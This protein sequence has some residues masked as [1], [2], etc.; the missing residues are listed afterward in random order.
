MTKQKLNPT[1]QIR[2]SRTT[3]LASCVECD[4]DEEY[5]LSEWDSEI[6]VAW[7]GSCQEETKHV[8]VENDNVHNRSCVFPSFSN[9]QTEVPLES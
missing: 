3:I 7:C 6:S 1:E 4:T 8:T 5:P 2:Q 9:Q